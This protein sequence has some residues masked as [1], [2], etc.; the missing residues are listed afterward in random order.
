MPKTK[1]TPP[2]D[3]EIMDVEQVSQFFGVGAR[4]IYRLAGDGHLPAFKFGEVWRFSRSALVEWSAQQAR[5]NL[6]NNE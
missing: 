1:I 2:T 3:G 6:G 4:L 5:D